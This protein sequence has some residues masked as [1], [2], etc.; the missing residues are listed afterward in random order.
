MKI[1]KTYLPNLE[2]ISASIAARDFLHCSCQNVAKMCREGKFKHTRKL[3]RR[4]H[5]KI[6]KAEVLA[7][8]LPVDVDG[9]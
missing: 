8:T 3:G 5:W 7:A 9:D 4:G 1:G 2:F 6:L